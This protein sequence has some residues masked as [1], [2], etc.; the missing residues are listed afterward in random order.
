MPLYQPINIAGKSVLITGASAGIGKAC[1]ALFAEQGCSLILVARRSDKLQEVEGEIKTLF[2]DA[3]VRTEI[4]DVSKEEQ[5]RNLVARLQDTSVD[6]LV[7]NAGLA[8]GVDAGDEGSMADTV[9]MFNTNVIGLIYLVKGLAPQMRKRN[10]GDIV[11][12]GSVAGSD[13]YNGGAIYCATK[14][15]VDAYSNCLRMDLVDTNIRVIG[16]NPGIVS[17]TEFSYVRFKGDSSRAATPYVGVDCLTA[18]DIADQVVYAVTRPNNVQIAQIR[19]YCNQQ[20]HAKFV[21]SRK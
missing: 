11:N 6:I 10:S 16:I 1:A 18:M 4:C 3:N 5:V 15:A 7:N 9:S 21:I 13:H 12:I 14:S 2:P 19:S 17:G 20:G 8:L